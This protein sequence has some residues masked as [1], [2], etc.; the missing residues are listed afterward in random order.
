MN[1]NR[2]M[3]L[4]RATDLGFVSFGVAAAVLL[5]SGCGGDRGA[6]KVASTSTPAP[7]IETSS[8]GA[9]MPASAGPVVPGATVALS[10]GSTSNPAG[11]GLPP[12]IAIGDLE[13]RVTPGQVVE[14]TVYGT[15]DV[16]EMSL[17]DGRGDRVAMLHDEAR[18]V[19]TAKYRVPIRSRED[20]IGLSVTARNE[21]SRWR[22]VWVFLHLGDGA[23]HQES[24]APADSS[25]C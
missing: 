9:A 15:P 19:W 22:R 10:Q 24:E 21:S 7:V 1:A 14:V 11:E 2:K 4:T 25:G 5:L 23:V 20:R 12:E 3:W 17:W 16:T 6:T 13:T 18:D 8:A